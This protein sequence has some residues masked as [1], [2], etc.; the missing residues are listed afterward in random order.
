MSEFLFVTFFL[1]KFSKEFFNDELMSFASVISVLCFNNLL[2][3]YFPMFPF[4]PP[5]NQRFSDVF[6]GDQKGTLGS[7]GLI[8]PPMVVFFFSKLR[9]N[10]V[11][12]FHVDTSCFYYKF[13]FHQQQ[14]MKTWSGFQLC[15]KKP[16][17]MN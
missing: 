11:N 12:F 1:N 7:K 4:D 10:L 17:C 14:K 2:T 3:L 9:K 16:Q 8:V 6:R 15:L 5:E 13:L